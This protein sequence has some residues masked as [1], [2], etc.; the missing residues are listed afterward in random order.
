MRSLP[1]RARRPSRCRRDHWLD[2]A[3]QREQL[4]HVD[5]AHH[6]VQAAAAHRVPRMAGGAGLVDGLSDSVGGIQPF[7]VGARQHQRCEQPVVEQEHVLHHLVLVLLDQAGVHALFQAGGDFFFRHR[8]AGAVVDAQQLEH[9]LRADGQQAHKGL[10]AGGHP[11]HGARHQ[12]RR[13]FGVEL[14]DALGH[15]FAED[16]GDEGDDGHHQRGGGDLGGARRH[17]K[18]LDPGGQAAAEGRLAD[19]AVEHADGSDAHLHRREE[20]RGVVKQAQGRLRTLVTRL[21]HGREPCLAA[22]RQGHF[23]HGKNAVEQ[24]QKS[25][26]QKVH[27]SGV[28]APG[29]K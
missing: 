15:Q 20:L 19:D 3:A 17:A 6:V 21:P 2:L 12:A 26:Q 1:P 4:G 13:G 11:H 7:D 8:A 25:N 16:D 23:R 24:R 14:P 27:D 10:G 9:R 29:A 5:H 18:G 22:G 28:W